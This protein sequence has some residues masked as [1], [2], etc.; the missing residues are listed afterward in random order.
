MQVVNRNLALRSC[1]TLHT[2]LCLPARV[3]PA[4][5][6]GRAAL[7]GWRLHR[8]IGPIDDA[9]DHRKHRIAGILDAKVA[10]PRRRAVVT[11]ISAQ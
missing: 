9:A 3:T 4:C 11:A 10:A 5:A 2:R 7:A 1:C 8:L 6:R